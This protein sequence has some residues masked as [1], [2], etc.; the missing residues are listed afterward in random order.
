[1]F[2]TVL[3]ALRKYPP[4]TLLVRKSSKDYPIPGSDVV[5]PKGTTISIPVFSIQRDPEYYPNPENFEPERFSADATTTR[6]NMTFLPFG[7][8]P[9][10]C[11]GSRFG[12]MQARVGLVT[13]LLN[14]EFSPSEKT[15]IPMVFD[16]TSVVLSPKDGLWLNL[17]KIE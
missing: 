9:R 6:D 12:M 3:E 10:N 14:Y 7:D 8:G 11:I 16:E 17:K 1:M 4:V 2:I 13:L 5:L 15:P